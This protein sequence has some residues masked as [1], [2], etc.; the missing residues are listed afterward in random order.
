M[1]DGPAEAL[2]WGKVRHAGNTF[3]PQHRF[4]GPH[5]RDPSS[6]MLTAQQGHT[7]KM[8]KTRNET[9]LMLITLLFTV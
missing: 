1:G 7:G 6:W 8:S 3:T 9:D 5:G 2:V 4:L